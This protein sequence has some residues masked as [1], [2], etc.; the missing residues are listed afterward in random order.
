M[1]MPTVNSVGANQAGVT[2]LTIPPGTPHTANDIDIML[3]TTKGGALTLPTPAG[4]VEVTA[5]AQLLGAEATGIR[6][7]VWW[8]RWNGTDGSAVT[9]DSGAA[10]HGRMISISGCKTSGDPWNVT[11]TGTTDSSA[12]TSL[13]AAGA[14]TSAADCLVLAM[15]CQDL[16]D[17]NGT[18]EFGT[19]TNTD[20]A[21]LTE[22]IDNTSTASTGTAIW[23]A[24]GEKAAAGAYGAT[25]LTTVTTARRLCATIALE[26]A[27]AA[28]KP[29]RPTVVNFAVTRAS[30][31]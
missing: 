9:N 22:R 11:S 5:V 23:M 6:M 28:A 14:T 1:G 31:Y 13:S 29:P 27:S 20:L 12:D 21:N 24:S 7:T 26:G 19:P 15:A 10:Q 25:T 2:A 17:A 8:R 16:P 3:I 30:T 18:G 4:F